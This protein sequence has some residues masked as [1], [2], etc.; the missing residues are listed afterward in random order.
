MILQNWKLAEMTTLFNGLETLLQEIQY[1]FSIGDAG[2]ASWSANV[3]I[4]LAS[5]GVGTTQLSVLQPG[6]PFII[7][8]KKG[9]A[10]G[11][12]KIFMPSQAP[13]NEQEVS[14]SKTITGRY[15]EGS[16]TSVTIGPAQQW[17]RMVSQATE[18][19]VVTST[20]WR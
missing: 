4:V 9:S 3:K 8:G 13:L 6:E 20:T 17:I 16:L 18:L 11:T 10:A 12:A 15:S 1:S 7:F 14:V 5:L 2:V 19:K